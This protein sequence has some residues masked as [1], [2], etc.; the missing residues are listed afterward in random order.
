MSRSINASAL[1]ICPNLTRPRARP[2]RG[3]FVISTQPK[4]ELM[5]NNNT[6]EEELTRNLLKLASGRE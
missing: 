5:A 2:G 3:N 1:F 6:E 4:E